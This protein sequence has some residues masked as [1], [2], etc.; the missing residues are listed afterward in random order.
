MRTTWDGNADPDRW[1]W[2]HCEGPRPG[3]RDMEWFISDIDDPEIADRLEIAISGRGAFRRFKDT[4]VSVDG[5]IHALARLLRE[6][7]ARPGTSL[8]R[9][10]WLP[11]HPSRLARFLSLRRSSSGRSL[12]SSETTHQAWTDD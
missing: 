1:L 11:D 3:Y 2:V 8:A 6:P 7:P 5:L 10:A 4:A 12:E 9:P